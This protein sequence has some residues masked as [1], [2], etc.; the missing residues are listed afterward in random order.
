MCN[1][2]RDFSSSL[3]STGFFEIVSTTSAVL[4]FSCEEGTVQSKS[5]L[6]SGYPFLVAQIDKPM[7]KC[8]NENNSSK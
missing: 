5:L 3:C 7:E 1:Y 6:V 8:I 4:S 2:Y